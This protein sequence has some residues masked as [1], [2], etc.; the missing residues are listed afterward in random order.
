MDVCILHKYKCQDSQRCKS[1]FLKEL[2]RLASRILK[3]GKSAP[4]LKYKV[5]KDVCGTCGLI[6]IK[7]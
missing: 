4:L 6:K 1:N 5:T 3:T 7:S 2:R